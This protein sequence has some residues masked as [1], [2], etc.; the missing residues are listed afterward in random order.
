[1]K[2][3]NKI[4]VGAVS[5]AMVI[6]SVGVSYSY[7]KN[8]GS[9]AINNS[10]LKNGNAIYTNRNIIDNNSMI[11]NSKDKKLQIDNKKESKKDLK[12]KSNNIVTKDE[13]VYVKAKANGDVDNITVSEWLKN[14]K[15]GK[16]KDYSLLDDIKNVKGEEEFTKEENDLEWNGEG[17]DI[18]YQGTTDKELPVGLNIT[19][20]LDGNKISAKD[21]E[22][23]SGRLNIHIEYYNNAKQTVKI[24]GKE[25]QLYVPFTMLTAM[26]LPVD[27]YYN[28]EIDN[29]KVISDAKNNIV[30][31]IG[32]PGLE[33]N[34]K[35][36]KEDIDFT[37][38][39]EVDITAD[40]VDANI[41]ETYTVASSEILEQFNVDD[42]G[43]LSKLTK[44]INKLVNAATKLED[45]SSE[46]KKGLETLNSKSKDLSNGVGNL[47]T[48]VKSY[49]LGVAEAAEG[50]VALKN[51]NK[52]IVDGVGR[53]NKGISDAYLGSNELVKGYEGDKG[54]LAGAKAISNGLG[55]VQQA[56]NSNSSTG[57]TSEQIDAIA[58]QT[59]TGA[60]QM[61]LANGVIT[62]EQATA[63]ENI[64]EA[65]Y[66]QAL[67]GV[68]TNVDNGIKNNQQN[69]KNA[70]TQLKTGSDNLYNGMD[71]IYK[72]T[73]SLNNGLKEIN[74]GSSKLY[75]GANSAYKGACSLQNGLFT[76]KKNNDTIN[77][78]LESLRKGGLQLVTG[79]NKLTVGANKLNSG[80]KEFN[81]SGMK[82][83]S[84]L[85]HS[86][87]KNIED[88]MEATIDIG[89]KYKSFGG[90]GKDMEGNCKFI[91]ETESK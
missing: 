3:I 16:I 42:I 35:D 22:G 19:Y 28:I 90:I 60:T 71:K 5:T 47:Y 41:K 61:A 52:E 73:V 46:L 51:G 66:K 20:K 13:T 2:K 75:K 1:M 21:L 81:N 26:I 48:G 27:N 74:V 10:T 62:A 32:F 25:E 14:S 50:S 15:E 89:G 68:V 91:I 72:G 45:G 67:Q 31:G 86:D 55:S 78:G 88:K 53:L 65:A 29:G 49:T 17:K 6:T 69:L 40:V 85:F 23:K 34:I 58:K 77:N 57:I 36:N 39:S 12:E 63:L 64:Y 56:L 24:N 38:P 87:V 11:L 43:D 82:K 33:E 70:I 59:A 44:S 18:Y 80:L 84:D 76:L 37:I 30:V 79:V 4:F 9:Y 7:A 83:I 8:I 54:A